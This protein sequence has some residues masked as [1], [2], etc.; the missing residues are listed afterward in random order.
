MTTPVRGVTGSILSSDATGAR[1]V[2]T[3]PFGHALVAAEESNPRILGLTA[4]LLGSW[5]LGAR[6][7]LC[8]SG[9][10]AVI[11]DHPNAKQ[12]FDLSVTEL[13]GL[14][15][16]ATAVPAGDGA[17]WDEL[18]RATGRGH[19]LQSA[20]WA[21]VKRPTGWIARRRRSSTGP[22][23]RKIFRARRWTCPVT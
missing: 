2:A 4:D 11:G 16:R 15:L 19:L 20:G 23:S 9:D 10:P 6:N 7:V 13:V 5:A 3:A 1:A 21:A 8:L 18:V 22:C 12:V 17:A 14:T